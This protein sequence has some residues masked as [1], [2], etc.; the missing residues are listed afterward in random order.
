MCFLLK[1]SSFMPKS[2]IFVSVISDVM[3]RLVRLAIIEQIT[4]AVANGTTNSF[5]QLKR[6]TAP[7]LFVVKFFV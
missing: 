1:I 7:V 2:I 6:L 5:G 3:T 4:A